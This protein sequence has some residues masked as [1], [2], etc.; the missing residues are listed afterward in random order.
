SGSQDEYD[1]LLLR[2][3][4]LARPF[5]AKVGT[6]ALVRLLNV[7]G[8]SASARVNGE[9]GAYDLDGDGQHDSRERYVVEAVL[10]G[11]TDAEARALNDHLDGAALGADAQGNDL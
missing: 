3:G 9:H 5:T 6:H 7:S 2:E 4:F 1:A 10:F 11:V 8:L